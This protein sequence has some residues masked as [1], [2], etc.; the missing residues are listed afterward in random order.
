MKLCCDGLRNLSDDAHLGR[1][2][3]AFIVYE[4]AGVPSVNLQFR[5]VDQNNERRLVAALQKESKEQ[6]SALGTRISQ[7]IGMGF[8]PFCGTDL[9]KWARRNPEAFQEMVAR[10]KNHVELPPVHMP[11]RD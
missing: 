9:K 6:G 11:S 8:C 7:E 1:R 4:L 2:G 5:A 3:C 10:S